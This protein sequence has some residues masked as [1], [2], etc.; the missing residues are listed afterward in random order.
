MDQIQEQAKE[1]LRREADSGKFSTR[2]AVMK[3]AVLNAMVE[4]CDQNEEF[5]RAVLSGGEL[6][7]CMRHVEAG[8]K[9]NAISDIDVCRRAAEFYFPGCRVEFRMEIYM[10]EYEQQECS[11]EPKKTESCILNLSDFL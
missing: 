7:M 11:E 1:K 5:A 6:N 4:F 10:S 2:G 3:S 8:I 9:G